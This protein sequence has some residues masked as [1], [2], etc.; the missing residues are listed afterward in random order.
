MASKNEH[1]KQKNA[2]KKKLRDRD[3]RAAAARTR[4]Q[5]K[6]LRSVEPAE[7]ASWP[8]ADCYISQSWPEQGPTIHAVF[9]R[10]HASGTIAAALLEIDLAERGVIS[11]ELMI[12]VE[13]IK[14]YAELEKRSQP[15]SLL[16]VD[17]GL[18]VKAVREGAAF[19]EAQGHEQPEELAD[20]LTF[21]GDI[22]PAPQQLLTGTGAPRPEATPA[23]E[24][25][26]FLSSLRRKLG[27]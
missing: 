21:L 1:R 12:G 3:R 10:K 27:F 14:L 15:V 2:E 18:V 9:T 17:P 25:G 20:A 22:P 16:I 11:A 24:G 5:V 13:P 8:V 23:A 4:E 7:A 6:Q 26:G 19:G